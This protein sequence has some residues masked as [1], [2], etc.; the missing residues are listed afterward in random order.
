LQHANLKGVASQAA[1]SQAQAFLAG[2]G[3]DGRGRTI[4][5]IL[6]FT[7]L[8]L[9]RVHD[10]IQWLFPLDEPSRF[11]P[12]APLLNSGSIKAIK[13]DEIAKGNLQCA[14]GRMLSFYE[15][16]DHWA[17]AF[18]HN[19]LRITRIL[20]SCRIL[21]DAGVALAAL[22]RIEVRCRLLSFDPGDETWGYW[23]QAAGR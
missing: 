5:V 6:S 14:L 21:L 23:E 11:N 7:N 15:E 2:T 10:Y 1:V 20:K 3:M 12:A 8:E 16:N 22:E 13:Q 18:D 17:V 9:E 4:E 19:L